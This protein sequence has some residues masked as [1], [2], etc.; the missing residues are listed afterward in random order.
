[1]EPGLLELTQNGEYYGAF[2]EDNAE[3]RTTEGVQTLLAAP[4]E[5]PMDKACVKAVSGTTRAD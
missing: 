1:M 5:T 2:L 4:V 3:E